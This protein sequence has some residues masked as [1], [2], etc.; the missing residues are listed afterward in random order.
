MK[1]SLAFILFTIVVVSLIQCT[2]ANKQ[3]DNPYR[4][5]N[6][7][8][9]HYVGM[10][11]CKTCHASIYNSFIKTG[12]GQSWGLATREKSAA[13]FSPSKALVYDTSNN[14]YYKP[15]WR[16]DSLYIL[17]FRMERQD[18]IHRREE[19]VHYIVGSGQHTNSH[20]TEINGY[21]HQAPITFYTQKGK[22]DLAPGFESGNN[23]RFD[24]KIEPECITC[25][26]GNS[27]WVEGSLNKYSQVP[28]GIDCERCHGP[29]S[30]HV[31][32]KQHALIVDTSTNI[33][34]SIVNPRK[35]SIEKQNN[36]CQRCHLQGISVLND[37]KTFYDFKPSQLLQQT[38][39]TFMP[40]YSED[41]NNMIMASHVERMK[42][43]RC[44]VVSQNMSC[45][46][47]HNPH[48]SVKETPVKHFNTQCQSCH[49]KEHLC[50]APEPLQAANQ[51]N[52]IQ[53]H[54][55]KNKS[56]DIPHVAV[57]DHRIRVMNEEV[58]TKQRHQVAQFVRMQ[59]YNNNHPDSRTIARSFL[60]FYERYVNAASFLDSAMWY[61]GQQE[62]PSKNL[63]NDK[64]RTLFLQQ[65]F[66]AIATLVS[67]NKK[68]VIKD[69]WTLYRIGE[70]FCKINNYQQGVTYLEQACKSMPYALDF[71]IK[72][73]TA[74]VQL[75]QL[76]RAKKVFDFIVN[77]N[78]KSA[79][80]WFNLGYIAEQKQAIHTAEM[81]YLKS[82]ALNPDHEQSLINLAVI[83][84]NM[85]NKPK[86]KPLLLRALRINPTNSK[87]KAMLESL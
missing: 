67:S 9:A 70:S 15:Y 68:E 42:Q 16:N 46:T 38:M 33:D 86:V 55:P 20:I 64:I 76:D 66:E 27:T 28:L 58:S 26:N 21:L 23:S 79:L 32:D 81:A 60:E 34:Y 57:T 29:G 31:N 65:K 72:L 17:E 63:D 49:S 51:H 35:L 36:L 44:Y 19:Y 18:T 82:I 41:E 37:G 4:N 39:N 12:M 84:Y 45:I 2:T 25:H 7:P 3:D 85:L 71:Q 24:R 75:S 62:N 6:N 48:I 73:G 87:T 8:D 54:V 56:I 47:C 30:I 83:Y 69:A 10:E 61:L 43:S 80:A 77:E 78:P 22:W 59:C 13:N 53:C 5:V 11:T 50:K 74:Y 14:L 52:C 40:V 1:Q